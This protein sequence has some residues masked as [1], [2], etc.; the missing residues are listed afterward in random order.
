MTETDLYLAIGLGVF[1]TLC[2]TADRA[3]WRDWVAVVALVATPILWPVWLALLAFNR[4]K[5]DRTR[6]P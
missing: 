4:L 2:A 5:R 6:N 1:L 3:G